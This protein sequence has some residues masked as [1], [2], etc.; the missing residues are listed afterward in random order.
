MT[1]IKKREFIKWPHSTQV[2][3]QDAHLRLLA[4]IEA[5]PMEVVVNDAGHHVFHYSSHRPDVHS[6]TVKSSDTHWL[7]TV[8]EKDNF[9]ILVWNNEEDVLRTARFYIAGG[10]ETTTPP[11]HLVRDEPVE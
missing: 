4:L 11:W 5:D 10:L 8:V 1:Q 9:P 6:V 7:S 2:H 3:E